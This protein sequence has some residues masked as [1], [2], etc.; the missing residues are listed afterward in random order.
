M[1]ITP[2]TA[3][4][5]FPASA[6]IDLFPQYKT[7]Y[8]GPVLVALRPK[9]LTTARLEVFDIE[10][11]LPR[12]IR[13][14]YTLE[15]RLENLATNT[16]SILTIVPLTDRIVYEDMEHQGGKHLIKNFDMRNTTFSPGDY[17]FSFELRNASNATMAVSLPQAYK[18]T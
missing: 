11:Y 8:T 7:P 1:I 16:I 15:L 2:I 14:N 12:C 18:I 17:E 6:V 9:I 13:A 10:A 4:A 3:H 5:A